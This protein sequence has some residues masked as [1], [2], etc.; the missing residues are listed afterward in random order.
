[1]PDLCN[2]IFFKKK[3]RK[4]YLEH[5]QN[6]ACWLYVERK[7]TRCILLCFLM[8]LRKQGRA[9]QRMGTKKGKSPNS[10]AT[11][12]FSL[13]KT[14]E[15]WKFQS[16]KILSIIHKNQC[17]IHWISKQNQPGHRDFVVHPGESVTNRTEPGENAAIQLQE[18]HTPGYF[19]IEIKQRRGHTHT[20]GLNSCSVWQLHRV[21]AAH[22]LSAS[23]EPCTWSWGSGPTQIR[24]ISAQKVS[25]CCSESKKWAEWMELGKQQLQ[26][27]RNLFS[28]PFT[29]PFGAGSCCPLCPAFPQQV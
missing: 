4:K 12:F 20:S 11:T 7:R 23:P 28:A 24:A 5:I 16:N 3:K 18:P 8:S 1:M 9:R 14:K 10:E 22:V 17:S 29:A 15:E 19:F 26:G 27:V 6:V 25:G 13:S 2:Y 21:K